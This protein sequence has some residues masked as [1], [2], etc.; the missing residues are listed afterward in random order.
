M[1]KLKKSQAFY[2]VIIL[3]FRIHQLIGLIKAEIGCLDI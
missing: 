1:L 3:F 2:L